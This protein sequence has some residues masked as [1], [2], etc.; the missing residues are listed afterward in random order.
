MSSSSVATFFSLRAEEKD[1][2]P[3]ALV[4]GFTRSLHM[5]MISLGSEEGRLFSQATWLTT[6]KK[7]SDLISQKWGATWLTPSFL[8]GCSLYAVV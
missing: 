2:S 7:N 3:A 1:L 4:V 5:V 6:V 8:L